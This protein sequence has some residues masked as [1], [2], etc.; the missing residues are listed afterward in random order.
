MLVGW[1]NNV[2]MAIILQSA[3]TTSRGA[4]CDRT[5]TIYDGNCFGN[6]DMVPKKQKMEMDPFLVARLE[7]C[8]LD[9]PLLRTGCYRKKSYDVVPQRIVSDG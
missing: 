8:R 9:T 1:R 6:P 7:L 4:D 5:A 3:T 2:A